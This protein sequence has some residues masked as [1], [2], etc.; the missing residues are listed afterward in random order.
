MIVSLNVLLVNYNCQLN[1]LLP[2]FHELIALAPLPRTSIVFIVYSNSFPSMSL[3]SIFYFFP[4][5]D[6][7]L[8]SRKMVIN[9]MHI[10]KSA[11]IPTL[12]ITCSPL[13]LRRHRGHSPHQRGRNGHYA[14]IYKNKTLLPNGVEAFFL[15]IGNPIGIFADRILPLF[16]IFLRGPSSRCRRCGRGP[17]RIFPSGLCLESSPGRLGN[18]RRSRRRLYRRG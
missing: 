17:F 15:E 1:S 6:H 13:R 4:I 5:T 14:L 8:M 12:L 7:F 10:Q 9:F 3:V 2:F 11:G 18:P 16:I